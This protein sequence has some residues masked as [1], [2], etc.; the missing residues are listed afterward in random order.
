M[1]LYNS[2]VTQLRFAGGKNWAEARPNDVLSLWSQPF[3]EDD[4]FESGER[5]GDARLYFANNITSVHDGR[6]QDGKSVE[7]AV[8]SNVV[9]KGPKRDC[10]KYIS[11]SFV[12]SFDQDKTGA[13]HLGALSKASF[14]EL[15][16]RQPSMR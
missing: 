5:R 4:P 13:L 14:A 8:D 9:C 10:D 12:L 2:L 15:K 6:G 16:R 7:V 1:G 11:K 3:V